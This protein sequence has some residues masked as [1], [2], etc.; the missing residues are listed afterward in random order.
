MNA[1]TFGQ[2]LKAARELRNMTQAVLAVRS[3]LS[4]PTIS[5]LETGESGASVK[6]CAKLSI[7]LDVSLDW[8][9]TGNGRGPALPA[10]APHVPEVANVA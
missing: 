5:C 10:N 9:L 3:G 7:A 2:R 6:S 8:L 1:D 4:Q